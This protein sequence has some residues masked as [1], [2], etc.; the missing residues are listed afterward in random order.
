ML[1]GETGFAVMNV[2]LPASFEEHLRAA[3]VTAL[4]PSGQGARGYRLLFDTSGLEAGP[5]AD[6]V[7][8]FHGLPRVGAD[9]MRK[10][11]PLVDRFS[12]RFL[13]DFSAFPYADGAGEAHLAVADP[14][15]TAVIGMLKTTLG[16]AAVLEIA[17][18]DEIEALLRETAGVGA[19][20]AVSADAASPNGEARE[21]DD[22]DS[23]RDMASGA[24]V[25]HALSELFERAVEMRATDI[26]IE[27]FRGKLQVRLRVDGLLRNVPPPPADMARALISRVKILAGLNIAERRLP[28]DGRA[29][30]RAGQVELDLRVATMPTAAGESAILR[31]LE[32]NQRLLDFQRLGLGKRDRSI[33]E[34]HLDAPHGLIVVTGPTGSGKTTTLASALSSLNAPL[35]K[36]LTIEDPIEY[37]ISGV[38]QSQV[39]PTIGLTFATALR[40]FL[41]QD[42]DVIMV[43][44]MR[45]G[46]TARIGIQAS[47]TGH[48]VLTTLHT[49]TA[50]SAV[51]RLIDMGV[52]SFLLAST[53]RCIIAQRLVRVLCPECRSK[54][55]LT[56]ADLVADPRLRA[57]GLRE[58]DGIGVPV[59]CPRCAGVGYRGRQAVYE[60]LEITEPVRRQIG[61]RADDLMIEKEARAGGMTTMVEDGVAKCRAGVTSVEEIFRVTASR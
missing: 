32:R 31:V 42:P 29:R 41:R 23:L 43:G 15:D 7:A 51:T 36:I 22:L 59:G 25:V 6:Q 5:F 33:L 58:G 24:P 49:N 14:S 1:D 16:G 57:L 19:A 53:L 44:E 45:D 27:P 52:E 55:E 3:G 10:G 13:R 38:N 30:V 18:F 21:D 48:L 37:E 54:R 50:A 34:R 17:A 28:Q 26:H 11:R 47:L 39:R 4:T 61:V 46:E 20:A 40:A 60:C 2:V 35:R 56:E 12:V 9:G 8:A